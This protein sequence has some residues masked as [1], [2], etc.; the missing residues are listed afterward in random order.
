[1]ASFQGTITSVPIVAVL[2]IALSMPSSAQVADP[3]ATVRALADRTFAGR[4]LGTPGLDAAA[5]WLSERMTAIGLQP[6]GSNGFRQ[7][8][9]VDEASWVGASGALEVEGRPIARLNENLTLDVAPPSGADFTAPLFH[10]RWT[11]SARRLPAGFSATELN[12][13]I[14]VIDGAPAPDAPAFVELTKAKP[15]AVLSV[16][17][18]LSDIL[19]ESA[20]QDS[21][22]KRQR[23]FLLAGAAVESIGGK[24]DSAAVSGLI[25]DLPLHDLADE[26]VA[27][28]RLSNAR[29]HM[30]RTGLIVRPISAFNLVGQ[31]PART[32]SPARRILLT[33]HYDHLGTVNGQI[34]PGADDNASGVAVVL[35]VARRVKAMP[36]GAPLDVVLFTGEEHGLIGSRS[37]R[38]APP[39]SLRDI[40][41]VINLDA[42]GVPHVGKAAFAKTWFTSG[43]ACAPQWVEAFRAAAAVSGAAMPDLF[44]NPVLAPLSASCNA[45]AAGQGPPS[46]QRPLASAGL[47][48]ILITNGITAAYHSPED[49]PENVRPERLLLLADIVEAALRRMAP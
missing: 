49:R 5:D 24:I 22:S 40:A 17:A 19:S 14:V 26:T 2:A 28:R 23:K 15:K 29:L 16:T 6:V 38:A 33:A 21:D 32:Q 45:I 37:F 13:A 27:V 41:A 43:L 3:M 18:E 25:Q 46:D 47:P 7:T 42:V 30:E 35:E 34:F 8:V 20:K 1:M 39:Y 12:G 44:E 11:A 48:A 4:G 36:L 31:I 9:S 10:L